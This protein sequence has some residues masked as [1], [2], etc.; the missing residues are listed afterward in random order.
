MSIVFIAVCVAENTLKSSWRVSSLRCRMI[1]RALSISFS[2]VVTDSCLARTWARDQKRGPAEIGAVEDADV[3]IWGYATKQRISFD[4]DADDGVVITS[5]ANSMVDTIHKRNARRLA[6][7]ALRRKVE[8][9]YVGGGVVYGYR[10]I[11][12]GAG[13]KRDHVICEIDPKQAAVV[14]RIFEFSAEGRGLL[15]IAKNLN[16]EK[17][18][19]PTGR[20]WTSTGVRE[21]LHRELYRGEIVYGKTKWRQSGERKYKVDVPEVEWIRVPAPHLRIIPGEL[22]KRVHDR[23]ARTRETYPGRRSGG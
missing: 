12:V 13:K 1:P 11:D 4:D 8:Q 6:R 10:N 19:S 20:G 15:S 22:W 2:P 21:M 14:R 16:A 5:S 7:E 3:E 9:G 23:Q 17:I 18:P